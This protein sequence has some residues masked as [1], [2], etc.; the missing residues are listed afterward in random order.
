MKKL[1]LLLSFLFIPLLFGMQRVAITF[2]YIDCTKR[3]IVK[4]LKIKNCG[5][6]GISERT[7]V[8]VDSNNNWKL[9]D[10]YYSY[11]FDFDNDDRLSATFDVKT[12]K[13]VSYVW[14]FSSNDDFY[15]YNNTF[16]TYLKRVKSSTWV[17]EDNIYFTIIDKNNKGGFTLYVWK[18]KN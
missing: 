1:L 16:N 9:S 6:F 15:Y 8:I 2:N 18:I 10:D 14:V 17:D 7:W 5:K 12:S 3:E 4:D 13:C 11:L